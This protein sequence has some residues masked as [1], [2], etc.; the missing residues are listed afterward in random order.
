MSLRQ[1]VLDTETTGI[2][3]EDGN[4]IVEIGCVEMIDR[5]LTGRDRQWYL[6]PERE[7]EPGALVVHGLTTEFLADKPR[8]GEI[9]DEFLAFLDGAEL[10]AHNAAFDVGFLDAELQ[11]LNRGLA[12]IADR[13]P[14][15]DTLRLARAQHPGARLSL[16]ALCKRYKIDRAHRDLHGALLDAR[17][18][19]QVYLAMTGGQETLGFA[20]EQ[21]LD[22]AGHVL[23]DQ[24]LRIDCARLA[25]LIPSAEAQIAHRNR[26]NAIAVAS[27]SVSLWDDLYGG[28]CA[29]LAGADNAARQF[30]G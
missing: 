30:T 11:R 8:F 23:A 6:N 2:R 4:R 22:H 19:A 12:C 5:R 14:V 1:I 17:L 7:S 21:G 24:E 13:C 10:L 20:L 15:L 3:V 9:A 18:L 27:G 26:L 16:D 28:A 29:P 25:R